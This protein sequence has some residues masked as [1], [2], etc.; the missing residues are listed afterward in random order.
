[1][2][3][4]SRQSFLKR[5]RERQRAEKATLKRQRRLE[6]KRGLAPGELEGNVF[7]EPTADLSLAPPLEP[8]PAPPTSD[9]TAPTPATE[10]GAAVAEATPDR[11]D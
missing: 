7:R 10:K 3:K 6:R 9:P 11:Q 2:A 1:M 4:R 8:T 5:Q